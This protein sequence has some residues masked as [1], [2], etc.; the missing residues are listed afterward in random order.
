MLAKVE[1]PATKGVV[2]ADW[3]KLD[4]N[5]MGEFWVQEILKQYLPRTA[6]PRWPPHGR[7]IVTRSSRIKKTNGLMLVFRVRLA[8]DAAA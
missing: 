5:G 8:S 3:K 6:L 4:E 1:L 2:S 7:A